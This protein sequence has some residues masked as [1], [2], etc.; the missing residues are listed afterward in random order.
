VAIGGFWK[1]IHVAFSDFQKPFC[2]SACGFQ[3]PFQP[4]GFEIENTIV[5][6][7]NQTNQ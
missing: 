1:P 6:N 4:I 2:D 7:K 3:N 5:F